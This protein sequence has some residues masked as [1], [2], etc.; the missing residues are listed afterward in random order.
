VDSGLVALCERALVSYVDKYIRIA[1]RKSSVLKVLL[2]PEK[3]RI[4]A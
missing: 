4:K 3:E 2:I 1:G